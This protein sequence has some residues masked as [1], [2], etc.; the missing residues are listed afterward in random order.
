ML[1]TVRADHFSLLTTPT[2]PCDVAPPPRP[3]L[4]PRPIRSQVFA[5]RAHGDAADALRGAATVERDANVRVLG[6]AGHPCAGLH[7]VPTA[8]TTRPSPS[9]VMDPP[10]SP[11]AHAPRAQVRRQPQHHVA[12]RLHAGGRIRRVRDHFQ[13]HARYRDERGRARPGL[14]APAARPRGQNHRRRSRRE[15]Q[16]SPPALA[17]PRSSVNCDCASVYIARRCMHTA[18]LGDDPRLWW[19]R[20]TKTHTQQ[21]SDRNP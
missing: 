1:A 18:Q 14:A 19:L 20:H 12:V 3:T 9:G 4:P 8:T 16:A 21:A 17:T 11:R 13:R 6:A 10:V 7:W 15:R 2:L 5:A